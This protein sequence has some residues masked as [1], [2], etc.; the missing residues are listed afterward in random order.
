MYPIPPGEHLIETRTC[1]F[2]HGEFPITDKDMSFY[3]KVSPVFGGKKYL[4]PPPTLCPDC[5][6]QRRLSFR[7]ERK[8][9]KRKCDA[10]G[11]EIVSIYSPDKPYTVYHQEYWWSDAWDPMSYGKE[12]D[13]GRGV[14]EQMRELMGEVPRP[15]LLNTNIENSEYVNYSSYIKDSYL[16]F[17]ATQSEQV[18]YGSNL[19]FVKNSVD[20]TDV[21]YCENCSHLLD[22]SN[23]NNVHDGWGCNWSHDCYHVE[24]LENAHHCFMSHTVYNKSYIF[25]N[26]ECTKE[27]YE[28]RMTEFQKLPQ[29]TQDRLIQEWKTEYRK[30]KIYPYHLSVK[31]ENSTGHGLLNVKNATACYSIQ[32]A[33]DI[34]YS[35]NSANLK[36]CYD[37]GS[38]G[39]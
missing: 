28:K 5:R 8:L 21:S 38:V 18:F 39:E 9:Y 31:F 17:D 23:C 25:Q 12:F 13:F 27:E 19:E 16:I 14:F 6:Q 7:N 26:T 34:K 1:K 22:S 11:K 10:T 29:K 24:D 36:D 3:E 15:S 20:M 33:E 32:E 30:T 37:V 35:S 2:C 4:I